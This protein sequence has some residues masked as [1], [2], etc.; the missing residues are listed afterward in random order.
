MK[1]ELLIFS[2]FL[3]CAISVSAD[4]KTCVPITNNTPALNVLATLRETRDACRWGAST[5][6]IVL[7]VG[8]WGKHPLTV[9]TFLMATNSRGHAG[10]APAPHGYRLNLLLKDANQHAVKRTDTGD[11]LCEP[12]GILMRRRMRIEAMNGIYAL[13]SN[14][15]KE[16]DAPFNLLSCFNI[17]KP[18]NYTLFVK[19]VLYWRK[20]PP[21]AEIIPIDIPETTLQITVTQ[22]D[23]DCNKALKEIAN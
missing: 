15:P 19:G 21:P 18:G 1:A 20:L 7:G 16:Y 10:P 11:A 13:G 22:A 12:V 17:E 5:N 2:V 6:D 23:I 9:H 4:E 3:A 8:I 14:S